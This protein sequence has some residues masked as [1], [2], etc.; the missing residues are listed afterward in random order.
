MR[1]GSY[2]SNGVMASDCHYCAMLVYSTTEAG[3][4]DGFCGTGVG[5]GSDSYLMDG[6]GEREGDTMWGGEIPGEREG[7]DLFH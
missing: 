3:D 1:N 5:F 4:G 6:D 2:F 7:W